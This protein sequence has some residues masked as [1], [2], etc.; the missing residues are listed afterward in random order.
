MDRSEAQRTLS[1]LESEVASAKEILL[2]TEIENAAA[3]EKVAEI[4]A[5]LKEEGIDTEDLEGEAQR[6][7][8][9]LDELLQ[10]GIKEIRTFKE[11]LAGADGPVEH[12]AV[13]EVKTPPSSGD[14]DHRS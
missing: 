12:E 2:R 3:E 13:G 7:Q 6:I 8:T 5:F 1:L 14:F 9:E 4:D 10:E 11:A